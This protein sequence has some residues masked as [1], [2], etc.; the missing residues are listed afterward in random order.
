MSKILQILVQVGCQGIGYE[1]SE[2]ILNM[3][4]ENR[5]TAHVQCYI[6]W[7]STSLALLS[8]TPTWVCQGM[9]TPPTKTK[10]CNNRYTK[11]GRGQLSYTWL[12]EHPTSKPIVSVSGNE[13]GPTPITFTEVATHKSV[14]T[15]NSKVVLVI[16]CKANWR[17]CYVFLHLQRKYKQK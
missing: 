3:V 4:A 16:S 10:G 2:Y 15:F 1:C 9:S 12:I 6:S 5:G 13:L 14:T 7:S 8:T 17:F 11:I